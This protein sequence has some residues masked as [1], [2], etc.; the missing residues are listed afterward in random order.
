MKVRII[1]IISLIC[2][3]VFMFTAN[4]ITAP[5]NVE[6]ATQAELKQ[7]LKEKEAAV[8]KAKKEKASQEKIKK[9]LDEQI[10]ALQELINACN[11]EIAA[12]NSQISERQAKIDK[13]LADMEKDKELFRKRIREIYMSGNQSNVQ[14]LLG[15]ENFSEFLVLAQMTKN[16][17]A[18]DAQMIEK[19]NAA[20][21][22]I[23]KEQAEIQVLLDK[24]LAV[25]KELNSQ[26]KS[27]DSKVSEVNGVISKLNRDIKADQAAM[28]KISSQINSGSSNTNISFSGGNFL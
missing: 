6:A 9:A 13:Q 12:Y 26:K 28:D 2:C 8:A 14:I 11:A 1:K 4:V 18:K 20:I 21:K 24:Q 7:Q 19:I 25:K 10:A 5:V 23:E 22:V 17:S 15:A 27:L 3:I 16:L